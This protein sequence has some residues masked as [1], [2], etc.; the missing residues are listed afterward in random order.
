MCAFRAIPVA[1]KICSKKWDDRAFELHRKKLAGIKPS[2]DNSAPKQFNHFKNNKKKQQLQ[3]ERYYEIQRENNILLGKMS[4]IM[5]SRGGVDMSA[6][7]RGPADSLNRSYRVRELEKIT[8]ENAKLLQRLQSK[9]P[10]I[11]RVA[12]ERDFEINEQRVEQIS[13]FSPKRSVR[14]TRRQHGVDDGA[15]LDLDA[16]DAQAAEELEMEPVDVPQEEED[17][18][19]SSSSSS[20]SDSGSDSGSDHEHDNEQNSDD[21]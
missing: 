20:S 9:K 14:R 15:E 3:E 19:S 7:A 12:L 11:S 18:S 13:E 21:E 1:S 5:A 6:P 8:V 2:I 4:H 17:S 10:S 16:L